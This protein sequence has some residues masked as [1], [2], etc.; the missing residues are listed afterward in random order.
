MRLIANIW[1]FWLIDGKSL[2]VLG[3][4]IDSK[5]LMFLIDWWEELRCPWWWDWLQTFLVSDW[6]GWY[7]E[8]WRFRRW[9]ER[10]RRFQVAWGCSCFERKWWRWGCWLEGFRT[11]WP[12]EQSELPNEITSQLFRVLL[13][14][15]Q[16]NTKK[17]IWYEVKATKCDHFGTDNFAHNNFRIKYYFI[18]CKW[19]SYK[20]ISESDW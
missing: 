13:V 14:M 8:E 10:T 15:L 4:E 20:L 7:R 5:H 1:G 18:M 6:R 12:A 11:N 3:D 17:K 9:R 19:A 2:D 16:C